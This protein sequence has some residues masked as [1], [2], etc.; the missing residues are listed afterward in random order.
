M[1]ISSRV[2]LSILAAAITALGQPA[3]YPYALKTLAGSNPLGDGGLPTQA[4]LLSPTA[5]AL[6]GL[7]ATY[8]LDSG[9]Y[10]I[11]KVGP[12][13]KIS[14][15]VQLPVYGDDM[16]LGTDG[17]FYVTAFAMVFKV[18]P[19]GVITTLAGTGTPGTSGDGIAATNAQIG[20]TGGIA[21]DAQGNVFFTERNLVREI[22][23]DG[24]IH[25]VVGV[26]NAHLY[27]GDNK[28]ATTA[29]LF[30]PWGIAIDSANNLYIADQGNARIRKVSP[31]GGRISTIAGT[32]DFAP[33]ANGSAIFLPLGNPYGLTLDSLGN[34]YFTDSIFNLVM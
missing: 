23:T 8:I 14:T 16:K 22:T 4:L 25:T 34:V 12:D 30:A 19:S 27:N 31:V 11:R 33:P 5:V 3:N 20:S 9:N 18:S 7:G 17:S 21:L 2:F 32:G 6:D 28:L 13:G 24:I 15:A 29:T 1:T 10:R 26:A